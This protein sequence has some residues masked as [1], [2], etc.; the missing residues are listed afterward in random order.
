MISNPSGTT[1]HH[2]H[3][4][5]HFWPKYHVTREFFKSHYIST[6]ESIV[7]DQMPVI[8]LIKMA[9][10]VVVARTW[11]GYRL[12]TKARVIDS[13]TVLLRTGSVILTFVGGFALVQANYWQAGGLGIIITLLKA[14]GMVTYVL[15]QLRQNNHA[16]KAKFPRLAR[17]V[18]RVF[19]DHSHRA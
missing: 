14:A 3:H 9:E 1:Q 19:F 15:G 7:L 8:D 5:V 17:S 12:D 16:I 11:N 2:K 6:A 4:R 13:V 18:E 10:Q